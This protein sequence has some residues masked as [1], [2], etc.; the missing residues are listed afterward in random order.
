MCATVHGVGKGGRGCPD[1]GDNL[2]GGGSGGYVVWFRDVGNDTAHWGASEMIPSQGGPQADGAATSE[3]KV[4]W[5]SISPAGGSDDRC[6]IIGGGDLR[7]PPSEN[8]HTLYCG[9]AHYGPVSGG[10]EASGITDG[11]VVVG[12]GR[13]GLKGYA[14]KVSGGGTDGGGVED[15]R[16]SGRDGLNKW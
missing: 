15:G 2:H 7:L 16:D 1:L 4:Q 11:Q 9:Q 14:Y 13:P 3:R 10:G 5:V 12:I 6:R 8:S